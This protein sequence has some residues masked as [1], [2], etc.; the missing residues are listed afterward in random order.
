MFGFVNLTLIHSVTTVALWY[1]REFCTN[2]KTIC[3]SPEELLKFEWYQLYIHGLHNQI[4]PGLLRAI[5]TY[6]EICF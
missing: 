4:I 6:N 5:H 2:E 3:P 1:I